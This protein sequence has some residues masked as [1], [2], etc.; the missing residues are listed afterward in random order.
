MTP[1]S[2]RGTAV[3]EIAIP[4]ITSRDAREGTADRDAMT[5]SRLHGVEVSAAA[6]RPLVSP[7][8]DGR[9]YPALALRLGLAG[10]AVASAVVHS[11]K[12]N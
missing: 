9:A 11:V 8:V 10:L 3:R 7:T 5:A 4:G 1:D 2:G 6:G 12:P